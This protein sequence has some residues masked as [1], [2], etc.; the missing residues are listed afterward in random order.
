M[1]YPGL[2]VLRSAAN[3]LRRRPGPAPVL[4]APALRDPALA[5]RANAMLRVF[6]SGEDLLAGECLLAGFLEELLGRCD[7]AGNRA[8]SL[9]GLDPRISRVRDYLHAHFARPVSI[10][11]LAKVAELAAF[12]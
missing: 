1:I 3:A 6:A 2:E 11:D 8:L 7:L 4:P 5:T 12:T 9:R 10:A